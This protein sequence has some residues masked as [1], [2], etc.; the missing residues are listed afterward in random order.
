[1]VNLILDLNLP[2]LNREYCLLNVLKALA[3]I[4]SMCSLY[5]IFLLKIIPMF[6]IIYKLNVSSIVQCKKRLRRSN[7]MI[8]VNRLSH[9]FV[10]LYVP[11]L[12]QGRH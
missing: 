4:V 12:A 6:Y 8:E 5:V 3:L 1:M 10:D 7:S 2:L 11:A 9:V